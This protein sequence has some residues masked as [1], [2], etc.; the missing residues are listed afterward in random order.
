LYY[1]LGSSSQTDLLQIIVS[2]SVIAACLTSPGPRQ[3]CCYFKI[4]SYQT[5]PDDF[6]AWLGM[7]AAHRCWIFCVFRLL[8][9]AFH[10]YAS[11]DHYVPLATDL[12]LEVS[13]FILICWLLC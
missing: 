10:S 6:I 11:Q 4:K 3:L 2:Q 12:A 1:S 8:P 7:A 13:P 9:L 5:S